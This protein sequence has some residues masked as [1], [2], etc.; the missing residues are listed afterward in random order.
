MSAGLPY[1]DLTVSSVETRIKKNQRHIRLEQP[2]KSAAAE[3]SINLR[4][5]T[6]L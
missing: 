6:K 5:R 1:V 3:H 4:H 2:D